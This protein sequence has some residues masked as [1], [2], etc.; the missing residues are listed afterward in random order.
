MN[1]ARYELYKEHSKTRSKHMEMKPKLVR[2]PIHQVN[3][4]NPTF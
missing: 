2:C 4:S 3:I 1:R